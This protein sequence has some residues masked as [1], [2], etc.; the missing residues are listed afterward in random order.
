MK[1]RPS[2]SFFKIF[3]K[4]IYGG[5]GLPLVVAS[6]DYSLVMIRRL[7]IAAASLVA[8]YG[9]V[10]RVLS[11]RGAWAQVLLGM[12]DLPGPVIEPVSPTLAGR[13]LNH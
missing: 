5:L 12:W 1:S 11:S 4:F 9:T 13:V 10:E 2:V 6:R 8:E 7:L 3:F